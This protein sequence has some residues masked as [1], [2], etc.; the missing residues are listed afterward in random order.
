MLE[1]LQAETGY[2][3]ALG[4]RVSQAQ[5]R[6]RLATLGLSEA[7]LARL[8]APIGLAIGGRTPAEIAVSAIAELIAV[9]NRSPLAHRHHAT[10]PAT[11]S[12]PRSRC[13][14]KAEA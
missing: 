3:G 1:A 12:V 6:E 14:A 13:G 9:R 7:Q 5:R 8:H 10:A 4:S 2:V 11:E